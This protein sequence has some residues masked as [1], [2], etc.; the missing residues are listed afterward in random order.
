MMS[1]MDELIREIRA[2]L[3]G[4]LYYLALYG[5][6]ALPDICGALGSENGRATPSKYKSWL[7]EN[8]PS[9]AGD[10]ELI[11][12][13]RCSLLHQGR[14]FPHGS[15]F[16]L[17]FTYSPTGGFH[18]FS[19]VVNGEQVG[20]VDTAIFIREMT[21]GAEKWLRTYEG[22]NTVEGNLDKFAR[23]RPEGLP[24]HVVGMPVIA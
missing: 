13:L 24:P 1:N 9:E 10:A 17:A 6:L 11:Y 19:T 14:A 7:K 22:T 23:L 2:A 4:G 20:W 12:G 5:A 18:N 21:S 15:V 16:P 3:A 8:V